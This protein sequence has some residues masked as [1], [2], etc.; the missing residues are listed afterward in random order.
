M[1]ELS[2]R[3]MELVADSGLTKAEFALKTGVTQSVMSHISSGRNKPGTELLI[4]VLEK[5]PQV[6]AEW[7]MLGKG[8]KLKGS[9]AVDTKNE[10]LKLIHEI[11][12]LNNMAYTNITKAIVSLENRVNDL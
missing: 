9:V 3:I 4:T 1:E 12:V 7:L 11:S 5:F 6:N 8:E 2:L 10:L